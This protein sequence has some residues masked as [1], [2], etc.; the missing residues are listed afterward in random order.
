MNKYQTYLLL[1][2]ILSLDII[3]SHREQ[4]IKDLQLEEIQW[5]RFVSLADQHLILQ[6]L[7]PKI[8]D[9]NL[10]E[11]FPEELTEHLKYIFDLTTQRNLEVIHQTEKLT[12]VL[13]NAGITPLY[14]KGVGNILDGLYKYPGERILHDIDFLVKEEDFD[15]AAEVI[16]QDGYKSHSEFIPHEKKH[17][18]HYPILFKPGEPVYV[19]L[20]WTSVGNRYEKYLNTQKIFS[21]ARPP[22]SQ[23]M[24][25]VMSD[26][27]K[28]IH[29]FIHAQLDHRGRT[30][31][32]E[33]MRNLYDLLLLSQ[34]ADPEQ[35]FSDTGHFKRSSAGYLDICY[36]TFGITRDNRKSSII[37]P[38]FYRYRYFLNMRSRIVSITS[39]FMIRV[40]LG[41]MVK[42]L[43]SLFNKRLRKEI[44]SKLKDAEW[45][46]KQ[47][48]YYSRVFGFRRKQK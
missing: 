17:H 11:Y 24:G 38:H 13:T 35:I 31:A 18:K 20:H 19:E 12:K 41:Y 43:Q 10:L 15:K 21:A 3:P 44:V 27:H 40:F 47:R 39:L 37:L 4:I 28:I 7:Y 33:F 46:K 29:N 42:P 14:L 26:E 34:K 2:K 36:D 9:H 45:Y 8:R 23:A 30:Y 22:K 6:S 16:L 5:Q 25:L 32:R 48:D 1:G